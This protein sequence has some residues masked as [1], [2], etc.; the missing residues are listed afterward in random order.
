MQAQTRVAALDTASVQGRVTNKSDTKPDMADKDKRQLTWSQVR[1]ATILG[2]GVV[3]LPHCR[4]GPGFLISF[5]LNPSIERCH[6]L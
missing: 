5:V 1:N 2:I 6:L 4:S 3:G